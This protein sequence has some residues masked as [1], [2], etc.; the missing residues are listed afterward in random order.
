MDG[1]TID[2]AKIKHAAAVKGWTQE[3]LAEKAGLTAPTIAAVYSGRRV[4][5]TTVNRIADS[6][7]LK[8][9]EIILLPAEGR[10]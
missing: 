1:Y 5:I 7:G 10:A 8:M 9:A 6:L 2:R 3:K 4:R